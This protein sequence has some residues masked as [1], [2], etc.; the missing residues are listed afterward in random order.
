MKK[1]RIFRNK[2]RKVKNC[3]GFSLLELLIT[4]AIF[5]ILLVTTT[6]ILFV[7]MTVARRV[8]A[9]SYAREESAFML[10]LLKKD[11]RNA[12]GVAYYETSQ[13]VNTYK[14]ICVSLAEPEPGNPTQKT[15]NIYKWY[16]DGD[17]VARDLMTSCDANTHGATGTDSYKTPDDVVIRVEGMNQFASGNN[18]VIY[19]EIKA[20][21]VGMPG[22]VDDETTWQWIRKKVAA[23]TRNYIF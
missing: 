21:S 14:Y 4:L 23:A 18:K 17:R 11:V 5:A 20:W 15:I 22:E 9:R 7:N 10:N 6:T 19:I 1:V 13:G 3:K 16:Q 2:N 12:E 8:K